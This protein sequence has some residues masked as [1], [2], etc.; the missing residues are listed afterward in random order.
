VI[1]RLHAHKVA[2]L[3]LTICGDSKFA[4]ALRFFNRW[5]L[6]G[7]NLVRSLS[8]QIPSVLRQPMPYLFL[9]YHS[10]RLPHIHSWSV[11]ATRLPSSVVRILKFDDPIRSENIQ[12]YSNPIL[13][14]KV[15][16]KHNPILIQNPKPPSYQSPVTI[17]LLCHIC[18]I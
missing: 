9:H 8:V 12:K 14:R 17:T 11:C 16:S 13:I 7:W 6:P 4:A 10:P 15:C 3:P 18:S 2:G 5:T 1:T